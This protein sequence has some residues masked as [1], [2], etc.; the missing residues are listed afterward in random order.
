MIL[1][2]IDHFERLDFYSRLTDREKLLFFTARY[3][4][5][6]RAKNMG[7]NIK[8]IKPRV[9][10]ERDDIFD[11]SNARDYLDGTLSK[12]DAEKLASVVYNFLSF[13]FKEVCGSIKYCFI[14]NGSDVIDKALMK[15]CQN[16]NIEPIY[17]EI[18]NL[19]NRLFIDGAG[20][21]AASSLMQINN[22]N[23]LRSLQCSTVE[24]FETFL[25]K[26][27]RQKS[28]HYIP[29]QSNIMSKIN[30]AFFVDYLFSLILGYKIQSRGLIE[31]LIRAFRRR[32]YQNINLGNNLDLHA[33]YIFLPLQVSNDSQILLN[34]DIS[35]CDAIRYALEK[36]IEKKCKLYVKIH[37]A[38]KDIDR[39]TE[40]KNLQSE[41]GFSLANNNTNE[42]V[43]NANQVITINSTVGLEAILLGKEV[44]FLGRTVFKFFDQK[45]IVLYVNFFLFECDYFG[46]D[47][48]KLDR[49]IDH[50][51]KLNRVINNNE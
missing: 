26:F 46:N 42:L 9:N 18:S 36:A 30:Y 20:V 34:S 1:I 29:Q 23:K 28:G 16:N 24:N 50:Y 12:V 5:Y 21:N 44:C 51:L 14:W 22:V 48:I 38:E 2:Y 49:I 3:S 33:D 13:S 6:F 27:K 7:L 15:Y 39:I 17:L 8:V 40:Y 25:E 43:I 35:N 32:R 45:N 37:P 31:K 47:P 4:V 19:P 10:I 11:I 41:L